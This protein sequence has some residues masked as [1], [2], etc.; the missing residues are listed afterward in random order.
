MDIT[1]LLKG[2]KVKLALRTEITCVKLA[3]RT[4]INL[5][6][7]AILLCCRVCECARARLRVQVCSRACVCK[8][9]RALAAKCARALAAK[10]ARVLAAK[11][12]RALAAKC[13]RALAC[14]CVYVCNNQEQT[15]HSC[16]NPTHHTNGHIHPQCSSTFACNSSCNYISRVGSASAEDRIKLRFHCA[17]KKLQTWILLKPIYMP[18]TP[19][20]KERTNKVREQFSS[21]HGVSNVAMAVDGY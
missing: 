19:P 20:S 15:W 3:L 10:C 17:M 11:C 2:E 13:A 5:P 1:G 12:A 8:C 16:S 7:P 4:E 18:S 6:N 21:R 9:A 14:F